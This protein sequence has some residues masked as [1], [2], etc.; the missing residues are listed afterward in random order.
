ML[1]KSAAT[2]STSRSFFLLSRRV[3]SFNTQVRY[4]GKKCGL[5][6]IRPCVN[7]GKPITGYVK[8]PVHLWVGRRTVTS[9]CSEILCQFM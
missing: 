9:A 8:V 1:K 5:K 7:A 2:M 4:L 6:E 3:V